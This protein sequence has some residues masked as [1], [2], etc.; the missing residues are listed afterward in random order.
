MLWLIAVLCEVAGIILVRFANEFLGFTHPAAVSKRR[1]EYRYA[2]VSF[3][4]AIVF[5]ILSAP[6]W[7][8]VAVV[9]VDMYMFWPAFRSRFRRS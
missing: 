5:L 9:L 1:K 7:A 4:G 2:T 6:W 3:T 8:V